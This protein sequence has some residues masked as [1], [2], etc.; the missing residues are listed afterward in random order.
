[1]AP[2]YKQYILSLAEGRKGVGLKTPPWKDS[3]HEIQRSNS[4]ILQLAEASEDGQGPR[5]AF[6]PIMMMKVEKYVIH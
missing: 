3:C 1:M 4:W 6:E 2:N 5:R